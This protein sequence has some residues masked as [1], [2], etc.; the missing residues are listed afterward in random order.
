M[1]DFIILEKKKTL[2]QHFE[3]IQMERHM[4]YKKTI[5]LRLSKYMLRQGI[6]PR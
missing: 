2:F 6:D 3:Q 5:D 4:C 1:F